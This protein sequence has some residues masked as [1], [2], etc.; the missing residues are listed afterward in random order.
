MPLNQECKVEIFDM[1][2]TFVKHLTEHGCENL[3]A[4]ECLLR[5]E[6]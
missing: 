6:E 2:Y 5:E 1:S 3:L 4:C